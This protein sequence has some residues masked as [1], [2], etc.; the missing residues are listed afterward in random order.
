MQIPHIH[1]HCGLKEHMSYYERLPTGHGYKNYDF[2]L[3]IVSRY[4]ETKTRTKSRG[5]LSRGGGK[6]LPAAGGATHRD[7]RAIA[8][9]GS[10]VESAFV[11][12]V[13]RRE[14]TTKLRVVTLSKGSV[15]RGPTVSSGTC[16]G[17]A[18]SSKGR[19]A[20]RVT[21]ASSFTEA[22]WRLQPLRMIQGAK[23]R[24][25]EAEEER[26]LPYVEGRQER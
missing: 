4:L 19:P 3:S 22:S 24:T 5:E 8:A 11:E 26:T 16:H 23:G 9:H 6:A 14:T 20:A 18:A 2:S 21:H 12:E 17:S 7:P 13:G 25:G 15:Q 10:H 1:M